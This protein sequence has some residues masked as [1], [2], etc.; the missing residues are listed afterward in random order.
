MWAKHWPDCNPHAGITCLERSVRSLYTLGKPQV[1]IG[2][3][4]AAAQ[5][6]HTQITQVA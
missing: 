4:H 5:R 6:P 1:N 2:K 3:A